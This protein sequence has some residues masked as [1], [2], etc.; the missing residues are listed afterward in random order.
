MWKSN[1]FFHYKKGLFGRRIGK[2]T[3]TGFD[4]TVNSTVAPTVRSFR[5]LIKKRT[6][7]EK[8]LYWKKCLTLIASGESIHFENLA[9]IKIDY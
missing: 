9:E 6:L 8:F 1:I 5:N 7:Y 3:L 4:P 2:P